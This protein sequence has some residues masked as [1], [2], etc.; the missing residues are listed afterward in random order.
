MS[1]EDEFRS[2]ASDRSAGFHLPVRAAEPGPAHFGPTDAPRPDPR[3]EMVLS[4]D[5]AERKR[6]PIY[7]GVIAYF[8]LAIAAVARVSQ[9]GNDKHNPGE[10]LHHARNKSSDHKDCMARHL[11]DIDTYNPELAEYE[12][13][14]C[15]AW[16]SLAYLQELEEKR[17]GKGL[18][19]G[20]RDDSKAAASSK[21]APAGNPGGPPGRYRCCSVGCEARCLRPGQ[22][23]A[24]CTND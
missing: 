22:L 6:T 24:A 21:P 20:A 17:L 12:D 15:H 2:H 14:A 3:T 1:F 11:C 7:S 8:P 19:P 9:R 13:A 23:C 5:S 16:R 4:A 10:P 18:P